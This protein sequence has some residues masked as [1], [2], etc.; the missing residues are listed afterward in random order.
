MIDLMS[1]L[2][3]FDRHAYGPENLYSVRKKTFAT[4][5]GVER[6]L[7]D[8]AASLVPDRQLATTPIFVNFS[9]SSKPIAKA[10]SS[11]LT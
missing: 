4:V 5:S 2:A 1:L 10:R 6:T 9:R 11:V 7:R 3:P 8:T